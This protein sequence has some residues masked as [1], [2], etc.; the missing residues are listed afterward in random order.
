MVN[1]LIADDSP[2]IR[3]AYKRVLETQADFVVSSVCEDG[4]EAVEKCAQLEIDVAVLDI[5]MPLLDGISASKTIRENNP[6]ISVVVV[7]AYDDWSYV[8]DL[9]ET[10]SRSKAYVLKNSLDDIGEL[11]RIVR[12]V[13][14]GHLILDNALIGKLIGYYER[15][16]LDSGNL[17]GRELEVISR[18][19]KGMNLQEIASDLEIPPADVEVIQG[20]VEEKLNVSGDDYL[21]AQ[22]NSTIAFLNLCV[23]LS[24]G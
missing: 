17:S 24:L 12:K 7:S 21:S 3:T 16:S 2:F 15:H 19:C 18:G 5:R 23:S 9:I 14:L 6:S 10:D 11:I 22:A 8:K 1:I 13:M 4:L 20:L